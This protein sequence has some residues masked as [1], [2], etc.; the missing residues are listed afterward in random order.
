MS[1]VPVFPPTDMKWHANATKRFAS[2]FVGVYHDRIDVDPIV[3]AHAATLLG[4]T[5]KD[6]YTKPELAMRLVAYVNELYDLLPVTHWFYSNVWLD[7]LGAKL[8]VTETL[9]W[10]V[11]EPRPIQRPEDVDKL[12][13]P[14][15][16]EISKS[17]TAQLFMRGYDYV[18]KEIPHMFV[19]ISFGFCL[20]GMA[21][22]LVGPE[23]FIV[24]TRRQR[25]LCHKLL[26]KVTQTAINGAIA[27]ANR[28]GFAMLVVGSVL[29]NSTVLAPKD[30]KEFSM[31]YHMKLIRGAFKG[32]AGPQ[33]WYHLC[34]DHSKDWPVW[35]DLT[36]SPFTVLH[37]G[38]HGDEPFPGDLLK[39]EFGH[40]LTIMVSVDTKI[41]I[42]P[43]FNKVY[44]QAKTQLL[45]ARDS[46]RGCILGT[47]CETPVPT[48]PGNILAMVKAARDF[49]TYGTW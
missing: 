23:R 7:A 48:N 45:K 32:G 9:P 47:A 4:Y 27:I 26:E 11:K 37:I 44:E 35:K 41:M 5:I 43:N 16:D 22:E 49:G 10:I 40:K 6:F 31:D 36:I 8:E 2:P 38:Y 19:P 28:Y 12:H 42:E 24:W 25:Q 17:M 3:L 13:V 15:V 29:A 20:F 18:Q 21:A 39:K 30:V 33:L 1:E 46:P 14:D 34:G